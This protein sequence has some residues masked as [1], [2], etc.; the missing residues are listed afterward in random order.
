MLF[1][2]FQLPKVQHTTLAYPAKNYIKEKYTSLSN[3]SA[4][5]YRS[6][7]IFSASWEV[8]EE[9]QAQTGFCAMSI[10]FYKSMTGTY[11][12]PESRNNVGSTP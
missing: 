3:S 10:I 7:R 5:G 11:F 4:Y 6:W 8:P 1:K 12:V 9:S 2:I